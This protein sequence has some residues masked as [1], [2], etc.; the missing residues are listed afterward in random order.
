[1]STKVK[2]GKVRASY[3]NVFKPRMNDLKGKLEYSLDVIIPK[4]DTGTIDRIHDAIEIEKRKM[5]GNKVPNKFHTPIKDGDVDHPNN[6]EY[7]NAYY[8]KLS[9]AV[10]PGIVDRELQPV[11]DESEFSSGDYCRVSIAVM[12]YDMPA[13]KGVTAKL[14]NIQVLEKGEPLGGLSRPEN[15]FTR[16]DD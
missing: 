1:M 7:H 16:W 6:P 5:F 14:G 13:N 8:L 10:K 2:T 12:A 11:M 4:S 3:A 15:D 9:S